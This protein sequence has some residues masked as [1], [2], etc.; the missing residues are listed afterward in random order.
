MKRQKV[1]FSYSWVPTQLSCV[2]SVQPQFVPVLQLQYSI[3][4]TAFTVSNTQF[5]RRNIS[6]QRNH[7]NCDPLCKKQPYSR[8][9]QG[10]FLQRGSPILHHKNQGIHKSV[11]RIDLHICFFNLENVQTK[12][13]FL[14]GICFGKCP[15]SLCSMNP[16]TVLCQ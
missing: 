16:V 2:F 4:Q 10:F 14:D 8:V 13:F 6:W 12:C 7:T 11:I 9:E 15:F 5:V 1:G 3:R